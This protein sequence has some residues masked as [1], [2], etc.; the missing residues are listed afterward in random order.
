MAKKTIIIIDCET[1]GLD[2]EEFSVLSASAIK[3]TFD[4]ETK[5]SEVIVWCIIEFQEVAA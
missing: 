4:T 3:F 1:N 2:S 5:K